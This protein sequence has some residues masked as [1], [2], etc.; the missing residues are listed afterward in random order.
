ML[1]LLAVGLVLLGVVLLVLAYAAG[2]QDESAPWQ[3][4]VGSGGLVA[5]VLLMIFS[6]AI[7]RALTRDYE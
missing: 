1:R 7:A 6:S 3:W 2:R 5:G 4:I